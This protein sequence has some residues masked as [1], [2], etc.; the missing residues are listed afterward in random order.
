MKKRGIL[1]KFAQKLY[2][3]CTKNRRKQN[4]RDGFFL[5][6]MAG[7]DVNV[8]HRIDTACAHFQHRAPVQA[9]IPVAPLPRLQGIDT[10][11]QF[12]VGMF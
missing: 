7:I 8:L 3:I 1:R 12:S 10:T 9:G 5:F 4:V 2:K 6:N 11:I